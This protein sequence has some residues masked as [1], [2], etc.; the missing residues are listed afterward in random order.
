MLTLIYLLFLQIFKYVLFLSRYIY[1]FIW[2]LLNGSSHLRISFDNII[3]DKLVIVYWLVSNDMI[4]AHYIVYDKQLLFTYSC[5]YQYYCMTK[6]II[7][8]CRIIWQGFEI[9]IRAIYPAT[10]RLFTVLLINM[11]ISVFY[12]D[13]WVLNAG[14]TFEIMSFRIFNWVFQIMLLKNL[15]NNTN[16]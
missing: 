15:H 11:K 10:Q 9:Q 7:G 13:N 4:Y 16:W 2:I 5:L 6:H 14:N 12:Y 3:L 8:C 1:I